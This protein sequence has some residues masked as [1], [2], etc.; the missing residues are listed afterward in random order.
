MNSMSVTS[1][2]I[3]K[4]F[5]GNI[6]ASI[7]GLAWSAACTGFTLSVLWKWF[8]VLNFNLPHLSIADGYGVALILRAGLGLRDGETKG[9]ED[10]ADAF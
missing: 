1:P 7:L 2:F 4:V 10:F 9:S 8:V 6:A 5:V 3:S